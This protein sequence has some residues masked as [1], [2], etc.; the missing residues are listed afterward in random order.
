MPRARAIV[1]HDLSHA[2]AAL[3]AAAEAGRPVLLLSPPEGAASLG[4]LLFARM[5]AL[6]REEHPDAEV[7]AVLDCGD[8][9]GLALAALRTGLRAVNVRAATEALARL[10]DIARQHGARLV[11][12]AECRPAL[13][14]AGHGEPLAA[15]RDW[16][17]RS[18]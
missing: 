13:D 10:D 14:L 9:P 1:V 8:A 11:P 17:S 7:E 15:C 6:A 3:A 12:E 5:V 16:L 4:P 2:R 18:P